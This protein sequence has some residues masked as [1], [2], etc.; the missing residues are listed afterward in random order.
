MPARIS[1]LKLVLD[2]LEVP[3]RIKTLNDRKRVQKAI[4]LAQ[5][6]GVSLGY[7]FHWYLRGPYSPALTK[8][9][10]EL[11]DAITD[12]D[13][14]VDKRMRSSPAAKLEQI[15]PLLT[16]PEDVGLPQQDWMELIASIDY[17]KVVR[18]QTDAQA[19][20]TILNEKQNLHGYCERATELL[21]E[22]NLGAVQV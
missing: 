7:R 10:Y 3:S 12:G 16:P 18:R 20:E 9:Y 22:Y 14:A 11:A 8:D 6:A 21:R 15:K 17:L 2:T 5:R 1:A 13:A 19:C 4:Y